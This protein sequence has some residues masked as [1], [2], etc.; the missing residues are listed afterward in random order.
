MN[1]QYAWKSGTVVWAYAMRRVIVCYRAVLDHS[2]LGSQIE[3]FADRGRHA[4]R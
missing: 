3:A 4:G 2:K 1:V